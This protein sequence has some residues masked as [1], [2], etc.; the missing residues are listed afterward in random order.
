MSSIDILFTFYFIIAAILE[1][2]SIPATFF[3]IGKTP[4]FK[5]VIIKDIMKINDPAPGIIPSIVPAE[6]GPEKSIRNNV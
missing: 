6:D 2:S 4:F 3:L 1:K 5:I